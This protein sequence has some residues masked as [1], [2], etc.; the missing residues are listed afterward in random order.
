MYEKLWKHL[1]QKVRKNCRPGVFLLLLTAGWCAAGVLLGGLIA[2]MLQK[3]L[4]VKLMI[5]VCAGGYSALIPGFL[6]GIFYLY[7]LNLRRSVSDKALKKDIE[8]LCYMENK[9][10]V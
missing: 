2:V 7:R 1:N 3:E 6:G 4:M 8:N 5:V 10:A 9:T